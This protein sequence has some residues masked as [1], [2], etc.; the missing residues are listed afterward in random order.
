MYEDLRELKNMFLFQ[1]LT[2]DEVAQVAAIARDRKCKAGEVVFSERDVGDS[3]Y[4]VRMGKVAAQS[5]VNGALKF[6]PPMAAGDFFGEIALFEQVPR[7]ATVTALEDAELLEINRGDFSVLISQ[8]PHIGNKIMFRIIQ[9][10]SKLR[11]T[12]HSE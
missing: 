9:V 8:S 11:R 7:T 6:F 1:L 5:M 12:M 2:M 4:I 10:L 3:M